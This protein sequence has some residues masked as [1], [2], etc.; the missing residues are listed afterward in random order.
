M[1]NIYWIEKFNVWL[2]NQG[3]N[4]TTFAQANGM[5]QPTIWRLV[6]RKSKQATVGIA[7]KIE[8][9]TGGEIRASEILGLY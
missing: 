4:V 9:G 6:N 8:K 1:E 2:K 5:H 7:K 3:L